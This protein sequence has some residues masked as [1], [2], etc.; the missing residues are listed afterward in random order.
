MTTVTRMSNSDTQPSWVS[1]T[2]SQSGPSPRKRFAWLSRVVAIWDS[3][4][5]RLVP[6][7]YE[8]E[9]GFHYGELAQ[10]AQSWP[11]NGFS[12]SKNSYPKGG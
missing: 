6:M 12:D 2:A 7:G 4:V 3:I 10:R 11:L 9:T 5:N 8:N 1:P